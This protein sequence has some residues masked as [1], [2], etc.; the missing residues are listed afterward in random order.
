MSVQILHDTNCPDYDKEKKDVCPCARDAVISLTNATNVLTD[1]VVELM[2]CLENSR[3]NESLPI[4]ADAV[5]QRIRAEIL[6]D[7]DTLSKKMILNWRNQ[8][9]E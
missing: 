7:I 5:R 6:N 1:K 8:T 4:L 9:N 2:H 3:P